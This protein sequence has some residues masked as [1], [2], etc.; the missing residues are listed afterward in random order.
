M[1]ALNVTG[2][3][4]INFH[5]VLNTPSS[6]LL[7]L[8][9]LPMV[10]SAEALSAEICGINIHEILPR[11]YRKELCAEKSCADLITCL[12]SIASKYRKSILLYEECQHLRRRKLQHRLLYRN[13]CWQSCRSKVRGNTLPQ[14]IS[15]IQRGQDGLIS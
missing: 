9:G 3:I 1:V 11:R 10:Q 6:Y 12:T 14:P 15:L 13:W 5:I 8:T 2:N 4:H 7:Y